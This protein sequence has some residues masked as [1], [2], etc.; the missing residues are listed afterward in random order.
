M[1]VCVAVIENEQTYGKRYNVPGGETLSYRQ[2]V[3]R[4]F[5]GLDLSER[6]VS[7]PVPLYRVILRVLVSVNPASGYS[8]GIANRMNQDLV[9]DYSEAQQ[10]FGYAP[11]RFL[12]DPVR[13]LA[14]A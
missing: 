8:S 3:G 9:F 12:T 11:Q 14:G 6:I 1:R 13:D 5:A 7:L 4:I 2:M 10:D